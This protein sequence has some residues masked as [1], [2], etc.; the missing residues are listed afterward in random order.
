M[1]KKSL[2]MTK[3]NSRSWLGQSSVFASIL[4]SGIT[5]ACGGNALAQIVPDN[6]LGT[7]NSVVIPLN[8]Q[9]D[10]IGGGALRGVSLF[11]SFSE[12]NIGERQGAYFINPAGV[13][14]IFSRVTGG[15]PSNLLGTLGVLGEA[16]LFFLNPNGI[17]IGPNARLD[18]R[19]SFVAST[20]SSLLFSNGSRFSTR[21]PEA[22]PLLTI[23]VPVPIGLQFEEKPGDIRVQGFGLLGGLFG[24]GLQVQPEKTLALVGGNVDLEGGFL[25]APNGRIELGSVAGNSLV[26]LFPTDA[27]YIF[28]Y[29]GVQGFQDIGLSQAAVV[30]SSGGNSSSIQV[31]GRNIVLTEG[32]QIL[33]FTQGSEIGGNLNVKA[34]E[35][36]ELI[37]VSGLF[38]ETSGKGNGGNLTLTAGQL[39]VQDGAQVSAS[40][41]GEGNG[42]TLTVEVEEL[43]QLVGTAPNGSPSAIAAETFGKG[44]GGNLTLTAGQLLVQ[45]GAQ[46][47]ASTF[48]E[49]N[50]GTLA[51]EVEELVQLVGIAPNGSPSAIT[52]E[53]FGKGNGGNLTLTAGQLLVQDGALISAS[54]FSEGDGGTLAVEVEELVQLV[55][56]AP[57]G[58]PP[59]AIGTETQGRGDGGNL[60]LTAGQLL[61]QD[62]ARVSASTFSEGD[63]GT[64]TVE[65]SDSVQLVGTASNDS[66]SSIG[67]ETFARG[68]GGDLTLTAGQ[69]LVQDGALISAS[70]FGE[71]DG[72]TLAVEVEELVSLVGTTPNGSPSGIRAATQ[73]GGDGGD[74]TLTAGQLLIQDGAQ[75]SASTFS[76]G[77]G[78]ILTVEVSD[79]VELIGTTPNGSPSGIA[80][81]TQGGG[82]GGNLT[83]KTR[84]LLVQ[85]GARVSASTFSEGDGSTLS[86]E[87]ED[88]VELIG[89]APNGSP[90]GIAAETQGGG[91]GGNLTLKTRQ[92]LVQDGATV[93]ASTFSEGDGGTL[94]VKVS[95]SVE[96]IGTD[97]DGSPSAI[98]AETQGRGDGGNLTLTAGQLLVQDGATVSASTFSEGDGGILTVEVSDLVEVIGTAPNGSPSG[99]S[100]ETQGRGDG[101]NLTLTAGQ[102]LVQDGALISASAFSEG[103]G[104]T[105]TAEVS[106]LVELIGTDADGSPSAITVATQ[107]RG[108]GGNL[109]LTTRQLLV[110]DGAT[111]SASTFDE[112]DG[113]NLTLT[114]VQLLVQDGATVSA[115]TFDEGDG[116]TLSV[117]VEDLVEIIGTSPDG[118]PSG[119]RAETQGR[120]DGGNLTLTAGQLLVQDGATVSASTS[121]EGNSGTLSVEVEDL[122]KVIGTTP[123][124]FPSNIAAET[125]GRGDGGNLTLTAG[126]LLVQ[127][128]ATVSAITSSEGNGGT[129]SV[130]VESLVEVIGTTPDGFPSAITVETFGRGNG[131]NLTIK[132][133]QLLVQDGAT[134]SASTFS[135][136]NGGTLSVEVEDLVELIGTAPNGQSPSGVFATAQGRG[137]GGNL[138]LKTRQLLVQ[139]GATV[140]AI[141]SSEGNGGTL[142]VEVEDLVEVIGTAPNGSPSGIAAETQGRGDGGNLTLKT[143]QLLVQ[144]GA[145]VSA[146]TFSEGN[147]GTLFVEASDWVQLIG[148]NANGDPSGIGAET[149][150]RGDGG[151]LTLTT[152]QLLVKDGATV[153]A[154]TNNEGNGGTLTVE[155]S[156]SILLDEGVLGVFSIADGNGGDLILTTDQLTVHNSL[157]S[158]SSPASRAGNLTI[159]ADTLTL[160]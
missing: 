27:G 79:L 117:E 123:D 37:G 47:S 10:V 54:A 100:A 43:V 145:T 158:V 19:G 144:D 78:G 109:T 56:T 22:S 125:Q 57:N 70:A 114:T 11:H 119:I 53:T 138:T 94:T 8:P 39:L 61:I 102:L 139:D 147:G 87:V 71:G 6:T 151:N 28:D 82:N 75:V 131:G 44:N 112:G 66:P 34:S 137:N 97:A 148:T 101:G 149:Q 21:N 14:T 126:Q 156:E 89:T 83:L 124:S 62:G 98:G 69:L 93:S 141:T 30:W 86:V 85:D 153:S 51:V 128:G 46:V 55:G 122:V 74:L 88:L 63:G 17:L 12:F 111:V 132:T 103:H 52:A 120:G 91:D 26:N 134:I 81:E 67:A 110:Q 107:G 36:V 142:S 38:A 4:L 129:L 95:D 48:G 1:S 40:T 29:E 49:G 121:S 154:S 136:G 3:A 72:G 25:F 32:S 159:T 76:E 160:N 115:S 2:V 96:L 9:I 73:G 60:T 143:R 84:Q 15:N 16:N 80:A 24:F 150:G 152:R 127:D 23:D 108:N 116:G 157:I 146:S 5:F 133:Q 42:G 106:D 7:E 130:E 140:S 20:A 155:A 68:N 105:L 59:S 35:L 64:L 31:Q 65:V 77:D 118:F 113:G 90:S 45:D 92:L 41:F 18:L 13:N 33:A 58:K 50:G 104:G 135:E 99:I